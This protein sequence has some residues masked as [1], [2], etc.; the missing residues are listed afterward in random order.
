M[1]WLKVKQFSIKKAN[2]KSPFSKLGSKIF[3]NLCIFGKITDKR[4]QITEK[5]RHLY[6]R[7]INTRAYTPKIKQIKKVKRFQITDKR[8]LAE[9]NYGQMFP[10]YGEAF[11]SFLG[12]DFWS[13]ILP[14][15]N[16]SD[17]VNHYVILR[18]NVSKLRTNVSR[19]RTNVSRLRSHLGEGGYIWFAMIKYVLYQK[20][21]TQNHLFQNWDLKFSEIYVY[22]GKLRTNVSKLRRKIGTYI[23]GI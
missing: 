13:M 19:L 1:G 5:N 21:Q 14:K 20:K 15:S 11:P 17:N 2:S 6:N 4:F 10:N 18:T 16:T 8:F 23:I 3:R 7:H 12:V 9:K 22:S